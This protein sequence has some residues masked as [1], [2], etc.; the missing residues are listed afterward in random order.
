MKGLIAFALL[1]GAAQDATY[2]NSKLGLA[3]TYP[4]TW[5]RTETKTGTT[6]DLALSNNRK[7]KLEVFDVDFRASVEIWQDVEKR[8]AE[9]LKQTLEK[10]WQEEILGVPLLLSKTVVK[11]EDQTTITMS[12]LLYSATARKLRFRLSADPAAYD[13]AELAWRNVWTS[14]RTIS[15][16]LPAGESPERN[17]EVIP[18]TKPP[19]VFPKE[20]QKPKGK[21]PQIALSELATATIGGKS[22][23]ASAPAGWTFKPAQDGPG[24]LSAASLSGSASLRFQSLVGE[25]VPGRVLL[26]ESAVSLEKFTEVE[27]RLDKGPFA[28]ASGS[29]VAWTYRVGKDA[30]GALMSFEAMGLSADGKAAW[31]LAY[32]SNNAAAFEKDRMALEAFVGALR[33]EAAP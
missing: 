16:D 25:E 8:T 24:V 23:K 22:Y 28:N 17:P 7:A 30:A 1:L 33:F 21:G 2:E 9:Q 3:F 19:T 11:D 18:T 29:V 12:G 26:R 27:R 14:L 5:N 32:R 20:K 6:F 10:Q 13:E 31:V 4:S 15:G